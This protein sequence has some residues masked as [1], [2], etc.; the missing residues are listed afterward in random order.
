M[1]RKR[2]LWVSLRTCEAARVYRECIRKKR[3]VYVFLANKVLTYKKGK[4]R[5]VYVGTTKKGVSR[6]LSSMAHRC[7]TA[8]KLPGV[9]WCSAHILVPKRR[10]G[11]KSWEELERWMLVKFK[12]IHGEVPTLNKTGKRMKEKNLSKCFRPRRIE[13]IIAALDGREPAVDGQ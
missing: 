13:R 4:S 1:A 10:P 9:K 11:L 8:L 12:E 5:I 2:R 7:K 6:I 3:L